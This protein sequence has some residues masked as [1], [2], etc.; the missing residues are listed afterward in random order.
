MIIGLLFL[1]VSCKEEV[2]AKPN[3]LIDK[4]LMTNILY[5]MA[6]LESIK[7][8][9]PFAVDSNEVNTAKFIYKKYKIDSSQFAQNNLYYASHYNEY[10]EMFA[11]VESRVKTKD[12]I[13]TLAIKKKERQ[14]SIKI[15]E[16]QKNQ[17][18]RIRLLL[19]K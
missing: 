5:D 8:Q 17:K 10:K 18:K 19:R 16:S 6:L 15:L 4:E 11:E 9:F 14:D 13:L 12:S 3:K 1:S 7:Y 2:V